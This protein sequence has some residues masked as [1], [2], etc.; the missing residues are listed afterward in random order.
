M[1]VENRQH[2]FEQL[3]ATLEMRVQLTESLIESL[4]TERGVTRTNPFEHRRAARFRC[5]GECITKISEQSF[6]MPGQESESH[7][8]VRDLSRKGMGIIAHQQWYPEQT[9]EVQMPKASLTARVARVRKIGPFC[10]EVGLF[11]VGHES[12]ELT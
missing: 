3:I 4:G 5:N 8:I 12:S 2:S 6:Q 1:L 9:V 7:A 10:F 11:I